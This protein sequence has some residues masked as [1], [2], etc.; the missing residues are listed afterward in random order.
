MINKPITIAIC[1][2]LGF[3]LAVGVIWPRYQELNVVRGK[4][5][6]IRAKLQFREEYLEKI[7]NISEQFK[8]YKEPLSRIDSALPDDPLLPVLFASVESQAAQA[9]LVLEEISAEVTVPVEDVLEFQELI[10]DF[11]EEVFFEEDVPEEDAPK[12]Q[13][14]KVL[15]RVSGSYDSF[16]N[17]LSVVEN[18]ARLIKIE[19]VSFDSPEEEEELFTFNVGIKIYSY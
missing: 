16:K 15:L 5:R 7:S 18:S 13:K 10:G 2:F 12:L 11:P 6:D 1:F 19:S 8:R 9:G 17:F 4:E 14:T 3:I